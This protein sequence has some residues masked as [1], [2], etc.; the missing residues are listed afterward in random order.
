MAEHGFLPKRFL[1][2]KKLLPLCGVCLFGNSKRKPWRTKASSSCI[3]KANEKYPGAATSVDQLISS[4]PGLIPQSSGNLLRDRINAATVFV[5]HFS[6]YV[7]VHLMRSVTGEETLE[8]K[9]AYEAH[10][11]S[12]G[13]HIKRYRADNGRF[14]DPSF[15]AAVQTS[16]Q[17]IS[18][19]GVGGH[20]QNG[21]AEKKIGDLT[22]LARTLL[23]HASRNWPEAV[24]TMLWPFALKYASHVMNT[25]YISADG[26]TPLSNFSG[27]T[28]PHIDVRHYHTFGC[29]CYVLDHRLQSGLS[30]PP[31]WDPRSDLRIFV[32]V[33]PI[34]ARS[35]AMVLNPRTGLV[36]PQFHVVFDDNFQTL[37]GLRTSSVPASWTT[38]CQDGSLSLHSDVL[39]KQW[40]SPGSMLPSFGEG[41]PS[42][43]QASGGVSDSIRGISPGE[44]LDSSTCDPASVPGGEFITKPSEPLQPLDVPIASENHYSSDFI[45]LA[46]SGL[47]RSSR[48]PQLSEKAKSSSMNFRRLLGSFFAVFTAI[49][50]AYHSPYS[51]SASLFTRTMEHSLACSLLV[52]KTIN[53]LPTFAFAAQME[54]NEV[55][56]YKEAMKQEDSADFVKAMLKEIDDHERRGHWHLITRSSMPATAKTI[57]SIWSFK[58]KRHPDGRLMKHKAR[59][60]AHGGMQR[61]GIDYWETYS[62]VVNWISV[63]ALL[64]I[65]TIHNLPTTS[66]DFVLAFPQADLETDVFMEIPSGFSSHLR[67]SHVLKLDKSLYGL[68]QASSNWFKHLSNGLNKRGFSQSMLDKCVYF[69]KDIIVLVYVDDCIVIGKNESIIADFITSLRNG[70]EHFEFTEEGSL[71]EYLGVEVKKISHTVFELK[72]PYLIEKILNILVNDTSNPR[73]VPA[74]KDPLRKD[75]EGPDRI[76][77]WNYRSVIGMLN[78]LQGSTRPDI[79]MAVHQCARF[80]ES[81]KLSHERAIL[82]ISR[83][84]KGTADRGIIY[85][86]DKTRGIECFVDASF[87]PGWDPRHADD[88]GNVLSR[89][90]FVIFYAGCPVYWCSKMQTEIALST[91][92]S[93]YIALSQAMR[94]VIP[95]MTFLQEISAI[96]PLH[97]PQPEVYCKVFEDNES[98]IKM[99]KAEKFT[100][101]TKHIALK[102]HHFRSYVEKGMIKILSIGTKEQIADILTKPLECNSFKYLRKKLNGW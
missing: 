1:R 80:T 90:G 94:E 13:V 19:C 99:A 50:L 8:A 32:G 64:A 54:Q 5:D 4:Q 31:K 42:V 68:R 58:R 56:T 12:F 78:Y 34:H 66:I 74:L 46:Q 23:L 38:L 63:R 87:A 49:G 76:Y 96:I 20:H 95:F 9:Q 102:Y 82:Y 98:C 100:P 6:N 92:E 25:L 2:L 61:W 18:F 65:S 28:D 86:P 51:S 45:N 26:S 15:Q 10:A 79:A 30:K 77:P 43:V 17:Q 89:T 60:C 91:A 93:E 36:S 27:I 40:S 48:V 57:L 67:R 39:F 21:I 37:S 59:I 70:E 75:L 11:G 97:L 3:R 47:R 35:V 14:A 62:P 88:P 53:L 73:P 69:K 29:P 71:K 24:T 55:Y 85:K 101:R 22:A 33:S 52:D 41:S 72:Q 44:S 83:Y 7:Y 81:P 84:L 16:G